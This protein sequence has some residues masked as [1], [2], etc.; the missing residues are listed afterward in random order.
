MEVIVDFEKMLSRMRFKR[1]LLTDNPNTTP[2]DWEAL[3]NEYKEKG[4]LA[5]A[6]SCQTRAKKMR[7]GLNNASRERELL[8]VRGK[9]PAGIGR[10]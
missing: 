2:E 8:M 1:R 6:A 5:N 4:F 3:A 10:V 7:E 9:R